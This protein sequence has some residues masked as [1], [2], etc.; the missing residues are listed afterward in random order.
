MLLYD[1]R[2][3]QSKNGGIKKHGKL[4]RTDKRGVHRRVAGGSFQGRNLQ[5]ETVLYFY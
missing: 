4:S 5:G 1:H 2:K 3:E